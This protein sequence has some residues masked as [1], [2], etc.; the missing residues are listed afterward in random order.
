MDKAYSRYYWRYRNADK[1]AIWDG[2]YENKNLFRQEKYVD[3]KRNKR[4]LKIKAIYKEKT[5]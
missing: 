5:F 2:C 3:D 4:L 1:V